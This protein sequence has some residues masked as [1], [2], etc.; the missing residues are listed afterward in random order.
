MAN[1]QPPELSPEARR[2]IG[3]ARGADDPTAE[4]QARVKARWL[5]SVAA[6]AGVSSLTEAARA[7]GG[8]G[9]GLKAAGAALVVAAGVIGLYVALPPD[10]IGAPQEPAADS[11]ARTGALPSRFEKTP[12]GDHRALERSAVEKSAVEKTARRNAEERAAAIAAASPEAASAQG[13][14][15]LAAPI[16]VA[17]PALP[18]NPVVP[19]PPGATVQSAPPALS[20][21]EPTEVA[22]LAGNARGVEVATPAT[23]ESGGAT[24]VRGRRE[25]VAA[26]GRN[27]KGARRERGTARPKGTGPRPA[28]AEQH[29]AQP[30]TAP[31]PVAAAAQSGQLGEELALL[32]EVRGSVQGGAPGRALELLSRYRTQ[33][34]RPILGMEAD[35]LR[36]DALCKAGQRDAARASA[37]AFQSDWPGSPLGQRVSSAC[38]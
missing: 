3:E 8:I 38:P 2:I 24:S 22:T 21:L 9:W 33:F 32:S 30:V 4:D 31:T 37:Q 16:E 12:A 10:G 7:A 27:A 18:T 14:A 35:A 15:A 36:V 28:A 6:V 19:A 11:R 34:G 25:K 20:V 29:A 17:A 5:A 1:N 13:P 26:I 23:E